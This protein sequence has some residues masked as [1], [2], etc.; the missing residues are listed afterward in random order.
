MSTEETNQEPV[1]TE[2]EKNEVEYTPTEKKAMEMGWKPQEEYDGEPD[3]WVSAETFVA[4]APLFDKIEN[5]SKRL[6]QM[7]EQL[8]L[9]G[10]HHKKVYE[11]AREDAEKNLKQQRREAIREGDFEAVDRLDEELDELKKETP[12]FDANVDI[13]DRTSQYKAWTSKNSWYNSNQQMTMYAD[14]VANSLASQGKPYEEIL[15]GVTK[16]VREQYPNEFKNMNREK[17]SAVGTGT[18]TR[19]TQSKGRNPLAKIESSMSDDEKR[20][21]AKIV[22]T[23]A[24]T[25]E[26]YLKEFAEFQGDQ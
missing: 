17:A 16:A 2:Q 10:E 22:R 25:K 1:N 21:M 11:K 24:V 12:T 26:Q 15:E 19:D 6:R 5:Q 7:Q 4:R 13:E 18:T 23:G 14:F 9:L 8:K 20:I 3:D